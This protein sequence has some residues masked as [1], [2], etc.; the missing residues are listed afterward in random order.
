MYTKTQGHHCWWLINK[1]AKALA[2]FDNESDVDDI[3]KMQEVNADM[4][5]MLDEISAWA[6]FKP[7]DIN[8]R[9]MKANIDTLTKK[10]R[11]E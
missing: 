1:D 6:S 8:L 2:G 4:Y 11:G 7:D 3:L 9:A 10:A 5:K